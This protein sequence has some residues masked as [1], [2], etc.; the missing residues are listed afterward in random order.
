MVRLTELQGNYV[1][2]G[3]VGKLLDY[4]EVNAEGT[5]AVLLPQLRSRITWAQY[6]LVTDASFN[7]FQ[8]ILGHRALPDFGP[9]LRRRV[10][11]LFDDSLAPFGMLA[12]DREF[13]QHDAMARH[14][15]PVLAHQPWYKRVA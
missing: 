4:F 13:D 14:Y 6:N 11:Q 9:A 8:M 10:I 1:R 5:R 12:L 3:G 7:E 15:R 2:S